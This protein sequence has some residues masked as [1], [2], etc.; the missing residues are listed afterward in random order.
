MER[1]KRIAERLWD[2]AFGDA[3]QRLSMLRA[4]LIQECEE[5]SLHD[6]DPE[7]SCISAGRVRD[8][9]KESRD[10]LKD[11]YLILSLKHSPVWGEMANWWGPNGNGY[12]P[13]LS[14]A[15][16]YTAEEIAA[17]PH[18]D[19]GED[20]LALPERAVID[21]SRRMVLWAGMSK[22]KAMKGED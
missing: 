1:N 16:R 21:G 10:G 15:G 18:W 19:D 20:T 12:T 8:L 7:G 11:V 6:D 13:D 22:W 17:K 4:G 2:L 3:Q 14:Q 5:F 9:I